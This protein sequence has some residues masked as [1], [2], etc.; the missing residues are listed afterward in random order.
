MIN[1]FPFLL[2]IFLSEV[3]IYLLLT[4][5]NPLTKYDV[6]LASLQ[7]IFF[8]TLTKLHRMDGNFFRLRRA[9]RYIKG[10]FLLTIA[11]FL[12]AIYYVN[13]IRPN[14]TIPVLAVFAITIACILTYWYIDTSKH[15]VKNLKNKNPLYV[16]ESYKD[17]KGMI[18][19]ILIG[20]VG[21]FLAYTLGQC[22]TYEMPWSIECVIQTFGK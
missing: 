16:K 5:R 8:Y 1:R 9:P 12:Y 6:I 22:R 14:Y 18:I 11:P 7:L 15:P 2:F 4:A 3:C 10:L 20:V 17:P 21:I 13:N 19:L